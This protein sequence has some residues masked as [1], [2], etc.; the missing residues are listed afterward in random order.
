MTMQS[1]KKRRRKEEDKGKKK[2][3]MISILS[4]ECFIPE[5][6]RRRNVMSAGL[7]IAL[8]LP[9]ATLTEI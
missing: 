7:K 8:R 4:I 5:T 6:L 9:E 2:L 1:R 3:E